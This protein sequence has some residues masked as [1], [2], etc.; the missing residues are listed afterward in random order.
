MSSGNFVVFIMNVWGF[1][2]AAVLLTLMP[3]PDILFV[4]TQS[5][6][7]G[8][9]A[10]MVFAAGLCTGLIAHVTAVSLG[11]SVLLMS[12]PLAFTILKFAGAAYLLYLGVKAFL[13]RHQNHFSLA[14]DNAVSGKLYRKGILMNILNPKVI[15]FFLAFFPQFIDREIGNPIPQMLFLGLIFMI[16][17]FLIFSLMAI[18]A[19]RLARGLMQEPKIA[20][21]VNVAE[22]LIYGVIG[23]SIL[24]V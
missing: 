20:L 8:R 13:A 2:S 21:G 14:T 6:T 7:R 1:I 16:Q 23:I 9:K 24:F 19:D 11:I 10:G 18:L 15:L 4:I 17:A 3:G 12:S 22:A 5:I